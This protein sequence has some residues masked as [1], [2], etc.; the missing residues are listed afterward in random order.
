MKVLVAQSCLILWDP[1]DC[2][3]PGCSVHA[4]LQARRLEWITISFSRGPSRPRD[5]T[6]VSLIEHR[7][8]TI[9]ATS[10][11]Q[12]LS[13]DAAMLRRCRARCWVS[14]LFKVGTAR[15]QAAQLC[16]R[17][18]S[19]TGAPAATVQPLF[20]VLLVF[21]GEAQPDVRWQLRCRGERKK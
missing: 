21:K 13:I 9:C 11:A 4:I 14:L 17:Q 3:P 15:L 6:W 5:R 12:A 8:F 2:S 19:P 1:M 7:F 18:G 10:E 16:W 20:L